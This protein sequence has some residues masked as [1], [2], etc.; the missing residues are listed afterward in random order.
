MH[1]HSE[2]VQAMIPILMGHVDDLIN[3][4]ANITSGGI[5]P[6]EVISAQITEVLNGEYVAEIILPIESRHYEDITYGS[7]I[8]MKKNRYYGSVDLFKVS[9]IRENYDK[10]A[11]LGLD[12]VSYLLNKMMIRPF[13][14]VNSAAQAVQLFNSN[15][16]NN[17][18]FTFTTNIQSANGYEVDA[19]MSYREAIGGK[20]SNF[21]EQYGAEVLWNRLEVQLLERRGQD[22][23]HTIQYGLNMLDFQQ[24]LNI[25]NMYDEIQAFAKNGDTASDFVYSNVA[26]IRQEVKPFPRRYFID[27]TNQFDKDNP[28]TVDKLDAV[29]M[30]FIN[31]AMQTL[32][33]P[34]V[35]IDLKY[36]DLS[37]TDQYRGQVTR[38]P[39]Q[40]GDTVT[41]KFWRLGIDVQSRVIATTWDVVNERHLDIQLGS[42]RPTIEQ[43]IA[44]SM[45]R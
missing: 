42:P 33:E 29:V 19:P 1:S 6:L 41:V 18:P 38:P 20:S 31:E 25:E 44:Q 45:R 28:P 30:S 11:T 26:N 24:E 7:I 14:L 8:K 4:N 35:N 37:E 9:R 22:Q 3:I 17:N 2:V 16:M 21:I 13:A 5:G 10:T 32:L 34:E 27:A 15:K 36:I 40:L 23:G 12:H 39:V 43:A